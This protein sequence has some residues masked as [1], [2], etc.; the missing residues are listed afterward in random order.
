MSMSPC[1]VR[2][3][4]GRLKPRSFMTACASM[5]VSPGMR[6]S[7]TTQPGTEGASPLKKSFADL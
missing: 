7:I 3:M 4:T 2:K 1:P 5:P 6:T